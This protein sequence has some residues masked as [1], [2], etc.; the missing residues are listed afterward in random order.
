MST[1]FSHHNDSLAYSVSDAESMQRQ[2]EMLRAM[3]ESGRRVMGGS[4]RT[5]TDRSI[6]GSTSQSLPAPR[7]PFLS[8]RRFTDEEGQLSRIPSMA[9]PES[10]VSSSWTGV[11]KSGGYSVPYG[12]LRGS[13]FQTQHIQSR[14]L[15]RGVPARGGIHPK[16]Y[17]PTSRNLA[18]SLPSQ[19]APLPE[20]SPWN[21]PIR[22]SAKQQSVS[23]ISALLGEA[24]PPNRL[25]EEECKGHDSSSQYFGNSSEEDD[26][27]GAL[28][29]LCGQMNDFQLDESASETDTDGPAE[30]EFLLGRSLTALGVM[31]FTRLNREKVEDVVPGTT[32][33][34]KSLSED[35]MVLALQEWASRS[36]HPMGEAMAQMNS[37]KDRDLIEAQEFIVAES[38]DLNKQTRKMSDILES[39]RPSSA[40]SSS[41]QHEV[42]SSVDTLAH[43]RLTDK[44]SSSNKLILLGRTI[45]DAS[46]HDENDVDVNCDN[47]DTFEAFEFELE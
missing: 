33:M 22:T 47:P 4:R 26:S 16:S 38:E 14:L 45:S 6:G 19:F 46:A 27:A 8:S 32:I 31:E 43:P 23:G 34:A 9:L 35:H 28:Q 18:H 7:A 1:S 29:Q 17:V 30:A 11:N 36:Y 39:S 13:S 20:N 40:N 37:I 10:V 3:G 24:I 42:F 41:I 25:D 12:S 5:N 15:K 2:R 21:R 44:P